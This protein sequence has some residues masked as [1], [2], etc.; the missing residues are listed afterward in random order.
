MKK[1]LFTVG[2]LVCGA[3]IACKKARFN[4]DMGVCVEYDSAKD[5]PSEGSAMPG[6]SRFSCPSDAVIA[7]CFAGNQTWWFYDTPGMRTSSNV[8]VAKKLCAEDLHGTFLG[9][10]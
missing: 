2:I 9:G 5:M 8:K 1:R 10:I 6:E 4:K 3:F 7:K